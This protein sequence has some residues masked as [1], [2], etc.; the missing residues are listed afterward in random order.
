MYLTA[1]LEASFLQ[2][3]KALSCWSNVRKAISKLNL[4]LRLWDL[5]IDIIN[6]GA[7]CYYSILG[8]W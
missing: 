2:S 6:L 1:N 8:L 5:A 7:N 4:W 3:I